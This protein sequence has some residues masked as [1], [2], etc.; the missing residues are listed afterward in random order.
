MVS[1]NLPW[2]PESSD[3]DLTTSNSLSRE[4]DDSEEAS[5]LKPIKTQNEVPR[6]NAEL[7]LVAKTY[8]NKKNEEKKKPFLLPNYLKNG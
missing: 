6:G 1:E 7:N 4:D 3:P 8:R 2:S 5:S